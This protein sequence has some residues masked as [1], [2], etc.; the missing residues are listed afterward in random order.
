VNLGT[1]ILS[2]TN[3]DDGFQIYVNPN[4]IKKIY[5]DGTLY[6][7]QSIGYL[8][9]SRNWDST[10]STVSAL[11]AL[12]EES[13]DIV[14]T[15]TNYLST[16]NVILSSATILDTLSA[17][18]Y[19]NNPTGKTIYVDANTGSD[20]R[21]GFSKYDLFKP[22]ATIAAAVSASASGDTV[23]VR[24]G[25]YTIS[26]QISLDSKGNIYFET[27]TAI[28]IA[29]NTV[30][31][32]LTANE[33]KTVNGFAQFALSDTAGILTQSAGILTLEYNSIAS[34][35]TGTLFTVSGGTLDTSFASIVAST[36]D[37]FVLTG[38]GGLVIRRSHTATCKQFLNCNTTGSVTLDIWTVVG[39][40]TNS[41]IR[42]A[43]IGTLSYRGVNLNNNST[44]P[45]IIF[46]Y[47]TSSTQGGVLRNVR[48][49][50]AG[51]PILCENSGIFRD[52]YLDAVKLNATNTT[53]PSI[54]SI[55]PLTIYTTTTYS[56]VLPH[57]N[58]TVDGQYN[59]MTK[60][61]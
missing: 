51:I 27:G 46:A 56:N 31:F 6:D 40:S 58:I 61:F 42:I 17:R 16:N 57:S 38:S 33:T 36:T 2:G 14:P 54:S 10:Y 24:A 29:G 34:T 22:F 47:S 19:V 41:T 50:T 30:A 5:Y 1:G 55:N 12:W 26:S 39:T 37:G 49:V 28:T 20:T 13:A 48:L 23:Y 25:A 59:I 7:V 44:A 21:N 53:R 52:I 32:S 8:S 18:S 11:S 43:N 60:L 4:E 45:C 9:N 15:V 35:S 3:Y